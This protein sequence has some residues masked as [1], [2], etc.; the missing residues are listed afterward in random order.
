MH[1]A[2]TLSVYAL[3]LSS[4]ESETQFLDDNVER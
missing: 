3:S 4:D 1:N 2:K